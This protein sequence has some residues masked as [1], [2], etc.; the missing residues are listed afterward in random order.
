MRV[1]VA[2]L[3][4]V[5]LLSLNALPAAAQETSESSLLERLHAARV[6]EAEQKAELIPLATPP[7]PFEQPQV[8]PANKLEL[9]PIVE[10]TPVAGFN[11]YGYGYSSIGS[12]REMITN[13]DDMDA[14]STEIDLALIQTDDFEF[15][16]VAPNERWIRVDLGEQQLIAYEGRKPV[17][18]FLVSTGLPGTPTVTGE[19][20]VRTKV[21]QQVMSGP[22][23]SLPGVKWIM[24]FYSEYGIHGSYWH[25]NFG[26][27]MSHGCV[28]MT[29]A[30][31]KWVFDWIGPV[32]DGVTTWYLATEDNPG[33]R[34]Y[35]HL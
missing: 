13:P 9:P 23:Y 8:G 25:E 32:W 27:P 4:L 18:A 7:L 30:D 12:G 10:N 20:R 6:A 11:G 3:M 16:D 35:V 34:I 29:N 14:R 15:P 28:N 2:L 21:S 24:Y 19:F 17:R 1:V 31:A 26:N 22:G 5:G 33:T